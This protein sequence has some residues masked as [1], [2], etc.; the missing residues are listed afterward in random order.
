[1]FVSRS[2]FWVSAVESSTAARAGSWGRFYDEA[3]VGAMPLLV[4]WSVM[5]LF[6]VDFSDKVTRDNRL[7]PAAA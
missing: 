7:Q 5:M 2:K 6:Q 3:A 4:F 1:M